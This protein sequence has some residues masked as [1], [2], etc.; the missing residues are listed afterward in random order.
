MVFWRILDNK[1]YPV[2]EVKKLGFE[3]SEGDSVENQ[4]HLPP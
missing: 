1:V 2:Q 3:E 4:K